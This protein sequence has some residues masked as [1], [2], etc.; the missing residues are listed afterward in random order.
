MLLECLKGRFHNR[1]AVNCARDQIP[2]VTSTSA[3]RYQTGKDRES[4]ALSGRGHNRSDCPA[5]FGLLLR[6]D[7]AK[8]PMA[9]WITE[10]RPVDADTVTSTL[11]RLSCPG[12][13]AGYVLKRKHPLGPATLSLGNFPRSKL[14]WKNERGQACRYWIRGSILLRQSA[15]GAAVGILFL[16]R[17]CGRILPDD[18]TR[19]AG[20]KVDD[21]L[22]G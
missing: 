22:W 5:G 17:R 12:R 13:A 4:S 8:S 11:A 21:F 18:N 6:E 7:D 19:A 3:P 20:V 10:S 16:D 14:P 15:A 9:Q 2:L 1:T